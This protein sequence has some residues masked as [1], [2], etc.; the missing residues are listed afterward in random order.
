M[1]LQ[2]PLQTTMYTK[3]RTTSNKQ[4]IGLRDVMAR[5][6]IYLL[7]ALPTGFCGDSSVPRNSPWTTKA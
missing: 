5:P 6:I 2:E 7:V 4:I 1:T 3:L